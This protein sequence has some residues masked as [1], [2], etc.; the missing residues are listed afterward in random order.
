MPAQK[1]ADSTTEKKEEAQR[2]EIDIKGPLVFWIA[3]LLAGLL[4]ALIIAPLLGTG[5]NLGGISATI[6]GYILYLPGS[7]ILPLIVAIWVGERVGSARSRIKNSAKVG[8]VNAAYACLIYAVSIFIIYLLLYY[9]SP[10]FLT[11][12]SITL[13]TFLTY[14][15]AVPIII[16]FVLIPLIAALSSARHAD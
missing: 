10:G 4:L 3:I 6:G 2:I 14:A 11:G 8:L 5:T 9:V 7:I 15:V 12:S 16:V 1:P 13:N